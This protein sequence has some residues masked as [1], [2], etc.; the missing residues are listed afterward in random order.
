MNPTQLE[1]ITTRILNISRMGDDTPEGFCRQTRDSSHLFNSIAEA[2]AV[3]KGSPGLIFHTRSYFNHNQVHGAVMHEFTYIDIPEG[4]HIMVRAELGG[5]NQYFM[6][7][8]DFD[9]RNTRTTQ[10]PTINHHERKSRH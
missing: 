10:Q 3:D 7:H 8:I 1:N 9:T 2:L 6:Y 4:I 5:E